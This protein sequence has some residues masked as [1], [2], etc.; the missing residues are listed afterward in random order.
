[1]LTNGIQLRGNRPVEAAVTATAGCANALSIPRSLPQHVKI[2]NEKSDTGNWQSEE[3]Q[4][5]GRSAFL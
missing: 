5:G 2:E 4:S 3:Q 1:M